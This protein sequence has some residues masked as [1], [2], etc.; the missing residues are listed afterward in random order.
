MIHSSSHPYSKPISVSKGIIYFLQIILLLI[1]NL[2]LSDGGLQ[3][4]NISNRERK[5]LSIDKTAH[6]SLI[7]SSITPPR[8]PIKTFNGKS[9]VN[10]YLAF[11][12][13]N[14]FKERIFTYF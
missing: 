10:K 7:Y 6:M 8:K 9:E 3:D 5:T 4:P 1:N 13:E 11:E 12:I 14:P 2:Y